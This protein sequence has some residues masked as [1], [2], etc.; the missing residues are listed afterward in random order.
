MN[1]LSNIIKSLI[2]RCGFDIHRY[3]FY[4]VD[5]L[6]I[7]KCLEIA[8]IDL[9]L[10]VGANKGQFARQL[11]STGYNQEIYSYEPLKSA[12]QQL[13]NQ[14]AKYPTW[15]VYNF[16]IGSQA[17]PAEIYVSENL[18]SSSILEVN[19]DSINAAPE[20]RINRKETIQ[21][22]TLKKVFFESQISKRRIYLKLDVQ[23]YE[24]EALKGAEEILDE[25]SVLQVELS[26]IPLYYGAPDYLEVIEYL[27]NV[28]FEL[29]S[30]IPEFRSPTTGRLLQFDGI[31]I[32]KDIL[33]RI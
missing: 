29:F 14:S 28:G 21:L 2:N 15:S 19:R 23:G 3:T 27:R 11:F 8:N 25:I 13:A 1:K 6:I 16:G 12:F 17:G 24:L 20:S 5:L 30:F 22:T 18:Y 7:K 4:H 9:V 31:F 10:D 33:F 26:T 32:R